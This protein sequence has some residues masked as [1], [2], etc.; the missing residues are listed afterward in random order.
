[1]RKAWEKRESDRK[2]MRE[3][4]KNVDVY[5]SWRDMNRAIR[6]ITGSTISKHLNGSFSTGITAI[7]TAPSTDTPTLRGTR[8][9]INTAKQS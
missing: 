2:R 1:M 6:Q 9:L 7:G 5:A 8:I 4:I 3:F